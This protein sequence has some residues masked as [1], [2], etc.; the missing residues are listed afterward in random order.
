M[1]LTEEKEAGKNESKQSNNVN[2]ILKNV[3]HSE[4]K[5]LDLSKRHIEDV[6]I[7]MKSLRKLEVTCK[8]CFF[9]T[10]NICNNIRGS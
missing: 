8:A 6:P 9:L 2:E 4:S 5:R 10:R 7:E 3:S 1:A